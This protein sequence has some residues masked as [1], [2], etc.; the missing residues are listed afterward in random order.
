MNQANLSSSRTKNGQFKIAIIVNL[1]DALDLND[2]DGS[3]ASE[4]N[5]LIKYKVLE[6]PYDAWQCASSVCAKI[7]N[8][9]KLKMSPGRGA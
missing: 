7:N 1:T 5:D 3:A 2:E 9:N 8:S 4:D 6:W